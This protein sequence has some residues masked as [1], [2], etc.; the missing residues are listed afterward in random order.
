MDRLVELLLAIVALLIMIYGL[1]LMVGGPKLASRFAHS[2]Y[3]GS[4]K[5]AL[6]ILF[7]PFRITARAM[8]PKKKKKKK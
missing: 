1:V 3:K 2:V 5:T 7:L 8:K 6:N 4:T